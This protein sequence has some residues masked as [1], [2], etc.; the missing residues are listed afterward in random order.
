M[1]KPLLS[2]CL[3]AFTLSAC[4]PVLNHLPGVYTLE[5]QQGNIVEQDMIDQLKPHMTKRQVL[6][7]MGS[8]MMKD[9]FHQSRWNYIYSDK[10]SGEELVQ[11]RI[12]LVFNGDELVGMQ[13]DLKPNAV[14]VVKPQPETTVNVPKRDLD[15]TLW[16]KVTSLF[17]LLRGDTKAV[18]EPENLKPKPSEPAY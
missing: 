10:I 2:V 9:I 11:K 7:I 6:Y 18:Q 3:L 13:G 4:S 5:I 16:E 8:P 12:T 17:G 1:S 14:P 15:R